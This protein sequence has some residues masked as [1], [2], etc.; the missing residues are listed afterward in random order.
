MLYPIDRWWHVVMGEVW[1][2]RKIPHFLFHVDFERHSSIFLSL[3][4]FLKK[5][6]KKRYSKDQNK[7]SFYDFMI[8]SQLLLNT[9]THTCF[10]LFFFTYSTSRILVHDCLSNKWK[11]NETERNARERKTRD[12]SGN[13]LA[14]LTKKCSEFLL[15]SSISFDTRIIFYFYFK[16][17]IIS[18]ILNWN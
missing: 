15:N 10:A 5:K 16:A 8:H 6:K 2:I 17:T 1:P 12:A 3:L 18:S 14:L 7:G 9:H 11:K 13:K 4:R